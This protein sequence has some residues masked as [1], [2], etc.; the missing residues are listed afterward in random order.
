MVINHNLVDKKCTREQCDGVVFRVA[1]GDK[2]GMKCEDCKL[3]TKGG[4]SG[5]WNMGKLGIVN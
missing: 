5:F 3:L 4:L 2:C 1:L